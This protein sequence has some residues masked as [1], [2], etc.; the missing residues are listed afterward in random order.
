MRHWGNWVR[1]FM[2]ALFVVLMINQ[3]VQLW[4]GLFL[5]TLILARWLGRL[6]CGYI[7]PLNTSM[8]VAE[9]IKKILKIGELKQPK[10]LSYKHLSWIHTNNNDRIYDFWASGFE[11]TTADITYS[12]SVGFFG[13]IVLSSVIFS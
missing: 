10:L 1:G 3:K 5:F 11:E 12:N 6:Y 2:F 7:C 4:L 9:K 13:C 8:L